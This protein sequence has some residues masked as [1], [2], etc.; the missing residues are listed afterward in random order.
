MELRDGR[1]TGLRR[2]SG[3]R[4]LP[5]LGLIGLYAAAALLA[6]WPGLGSFRSD[7]LA[8]GAPGFGEAA[9]GDHGQVVYRYW[10][11]G[12]QLANG[13]APWRDP[14]SF[15]P[16][17]EPQLTLGSWPFGIPFWP[18]DALFG[19]V[20]AWNV[21]LLVTVVLAGLLGAAWLRALGLGTMASALGGLAFAIAPYRLG[22][23]SDHVLG[24]VS[25][26]LPLVLLA[27]ERGRVA[28]TRRGEHAWGA[29]A[30]SSLVTFALAG[31]LHLALGVLP[32]ALAYGAIRFRR[33]VFAWIV[34]GLLVTSA[35]GLALRFTVISGA[36]QGGKRTLANVT[37]FSAEVGDFV[38]RWHSAPSEEL[39]YVGWLT[40]VLAIAGLVLLAR[41]DRWL[42]LV[43]G[44]A[45]VIPILL[46]FGT[47]LPLYAPL[48]SIVPPLQNARVPGRFMAI[49]D[50]ALAGLA[51]YAGERLLARVRAGRAVAVGVVLIA[52]VAADLTI[53][54]FA[55]TEADSANAAYA[56]LAKAPPGRVL[57]LPLFDP[58]RAEGSVYN[59]YTLQAP[60]QR[61]SGYSSLAPPAA[62]RFYRLFARLG[63]GVWLAGD[64]AA[65][66][67]VGVREITF[68]RGLY[69]D[70][71]PGA[72]F[73]WQGLLA[74]GWRQQGRGG[75]I[76]LLA[77][78]RGP[79]T[80]GSVAEPARDA[81]YFCHG[82][83][84]VRRTVEAQAPLWVWGPGP[85]T[86]EFTS[87]RPTDAT[88][89][90]DGRL[91]QRF[92]I[93]RRGSVHLRLRGRRWHPLLV[94]IPDLYAT[95]APY[96][97]RMVRIS[98]PWH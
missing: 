9:P 44:L 85:L 42:A 75:T 33:V 53:M 54:P 29:V 15:Q 96:G 64:D 98:F 61:P 17:V 45:A 52:L 66:A 62:F 49:A 56:A 2:A 55:P 25:V 78:E 89:W 83:S 72:W 36:E 48:R 74:H 6:A 43:L 51:A 82:W 90:V 37:S 39:V 60:R 7:Y 23:S 19:P 94:E 84:T 76:S 97:L 47:N 58:G 8:G 14:F 81:P 57:E 16:L 5:A 67:R 27:I 50:L 88:L 20:V 70:N 34:G 68:H 35:I 24:W 22:Q 10:L 4:A 65:L 13:A 79:R 69:F 11:L 38:D 46:A 92:Q 91:D 12:H 32:L 80:P 93:D 26:F 1:D 28:T 73:T 86:M 95:G 21:L 71:Y 31:Q 87:A 77:R 59:L 18:L 40:A 3:R 63:C 41:R 30:A